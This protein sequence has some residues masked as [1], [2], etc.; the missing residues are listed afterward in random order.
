VDGL[1]LLPEY[2]LSFDICI[3]YHQMEKTI[4]MVRA[5]P[6]TTFVLDHLGKPNV[7]AQQ[8]DPWRD[9]IGELAQ[10]PN[11]IGCKLSGLV[12]E[13]DHR[14][15]S[16]TDLEPYAHHVLQAFGE[17]R[18]MF[19]GDWPVLTHAASYRDWVAA[20]ER[21]TSDLSAEA[22]RKFWSENARRIYRM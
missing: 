16:A 15:W 14:G 3:R 9:Q 13:A 18:V 6:E 4:E 5:C 10:F 1:R 2:G 22:K 17:D 21:L 7:R 11:V 19:G 12:T 8:L 20:A